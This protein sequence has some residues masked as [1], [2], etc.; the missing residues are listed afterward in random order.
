MQ[1]LDELLKRLRSPRRCD[2]VRWAQLERDVRELREDVE[3]VVLVLAQFDIRVTTLEKQALDPIPTAVITEL[4]TVRARLAGLANAGET[5]T[6][7]I[8][9]RPTPRPQAVPD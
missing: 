6:S 5:Q 7:V 3:E 8:V 4:Q 2:V 9:D 1:M